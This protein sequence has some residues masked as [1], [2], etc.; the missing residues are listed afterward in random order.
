MDI[1][2]VVESETTRVLF[3]GRGRLLPMFATDASALPLF[4]LPRTSQSAGTSRGV[5]LNS[6]KSQKNRKTDLTFLKKSLYY[7]IMPDLPLAQGD[8]LKGNSNPESYELETTFLQ[9]PL[10]P[11]CFDAISLFEAGSG[12]RSPAGTKVFFRR[13]VAFIA[14]G[15]NEGPSSNP[16]AARRIPSWKSAFASRCW[17]PV[18]S[19][20]IR[21]LIGLAPT[22][23][24]CTRETDPQGQRIAPSL[25][26][27]G[28]QK[29][30]CLEFARNVQTV[31]RRGGGLSEDHRLHPRGGGPAH[32]AACLPTEQVSHEN[33]QPKPE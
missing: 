25:R 3:G 15:D 33:Q 31:A 26:N 6:K 13:S 16:A 7:A 18:V 27:E 32:L 11:H 4:G 28:R 12:S 29:S 2:A 19:R 21:L 14:I 8:R 1:F 24:C 17:Q 20:L 23:Y 10:T 9:T 30:N 22:N 5:H